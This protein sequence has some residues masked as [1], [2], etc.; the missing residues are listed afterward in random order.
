M[1]ADH[2]PDQVALP[3][4]IALYRAIQEL[5]SNAYRHGRG[6]EVRVRIEADDQFLALEVT[7]RGPGA[8]IEKL[9]DVPGL[10]LAGMREQAELLG[11][12]FE[13]ASETGSGMQAR[14]RWPLPRGRRPPPTALTGDEG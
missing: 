6:A 9:V 4:K 13:L 1:L 11:G 10:G 12:D 8:D 14:V 2:V 5:L 3:V 7:D